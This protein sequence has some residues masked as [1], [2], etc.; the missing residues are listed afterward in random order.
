MKRSSKISAKIPKEA[1][2][3]AYPGANGRLRRR[4]VDVKAKLAVSTQYIPHPQ[5]SYSYVIDDT[6]RG[7]DGILEPGEGAELIVNVT[8]IGPGKA[9]NVTLRLK[10]AA[11]EDLFLERGRVQIGAIE[12]LDTKAGR[13]KFR[14]RK[15]QTQVKNYL[16]S[17]RFMTLIPVNGSRMNLR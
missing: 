7:D 1:A 16:W 6:E 3:R 13:L 12:S 2:S 5:F 14:I 8:N 17:L 4:K 11:G 10:S 15:N 9:D